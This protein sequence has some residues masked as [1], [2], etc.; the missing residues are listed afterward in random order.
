MDEIYDL[1]W[2]MLRYVALSRRWWR[3]WRPRLDHVEILELEKHT[4]TQ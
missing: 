3:W 4:T 2:A 1:G